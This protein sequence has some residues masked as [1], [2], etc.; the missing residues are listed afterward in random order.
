MERNII[1][2]LSLPKNILLKVDNERN[3]VSRSR[4]VL[5]IL[6]SKFSNTGNHVDGEVQIEGTIKSKGSIRQSRC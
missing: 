4:F 6:E 2:G 5:R 1:I 3:D